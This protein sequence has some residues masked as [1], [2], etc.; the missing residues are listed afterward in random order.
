LQPVV[1]QERT[2]TTQ[3]SVTVCHTIDGKTL[4]SHGT[5][6]HRPAERKHKW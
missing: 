1:D 3:A 5:D 4:S 2:K 6:E